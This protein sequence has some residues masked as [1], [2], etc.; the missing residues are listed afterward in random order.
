MNS[1]VLIEVCCGSIDDGLEAQRAG[2]NRIELNSSLFLGGLTPSVGEIIQSK[3]IL[4]IP[5]MVMI[6][7]RSG[8]FCYTDSEFEVMKAD[9]KEAINHGADGIVFG[10][11]KDDGT[12]DEERSAE[13][14]ELAGS[15]DVVFHRAFDVTPNPFK[16]IDT[17][18]NLGIKRILTKGQA[19]SLEEGMSLIKN[20]IEYSKGK[21]EIMPSGCK[22]HNIDWAIKELNCNEI[23]IASYE[24]KIDNSCMNNPNVYFGGALRPQENTYNVVS[25]SFVKTIRDK[26]K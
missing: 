20:L 25:Y 17:L 9:V 4:D 8:G 24:T 11:L 18:V 2:A 7:P 12:I 26:T 16:A 15:K 22:T 6:R 14:V 5:V 23:H 19:N 1:N 10:I 21:L 13:I 3:K